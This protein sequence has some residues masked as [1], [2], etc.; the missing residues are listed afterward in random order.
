MDTD[1]LVLS[2]GTDE[3]CLINFLHMKKNE[4]DFSEMDKE[5]VLN[6]PLN[7]PVLGKK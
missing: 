6:V 2:F 5:Y 1:S 7:K 4:F 3:E